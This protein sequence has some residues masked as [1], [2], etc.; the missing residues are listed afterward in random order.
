[1][2]GQI[3]TP[4]RR[5]HADPMTEA[6]RAAQDALELQWT[7]KGVECWMETTWTGA[8]CGCYRHGDFRGSSRYILVGIGTGEK[9]T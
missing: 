8:W 1:M 9:L 7:P 5:H 2:T 3:V 4:V 6:E